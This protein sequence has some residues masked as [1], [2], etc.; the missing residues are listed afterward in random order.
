MRYLMIYIYYDK[1][2]PAEDRVRIP[3][4]LGQEAREILITDLRDQNIYTYISALFALL[5]WD[6]ERFNE[7]S[8]NTSPAG[9]IFYQG[10][11]T[12]D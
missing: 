4:G 3:L 6:K 9:S 7:T 11:S 2:Q 10:H 8:V 5:E 1:T 12:E